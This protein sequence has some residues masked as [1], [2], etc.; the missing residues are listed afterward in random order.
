MR[1]GGPPATQIFAAPLSGPGVSRDGCPEPWVAA[2]LTQNVRPSPGESRSPPRA[3][4]A[5]VPE[6]DDSSS[7]SLASAFP[8]RPCLAL[9]PL[10][11]AVCQHL[12]GDFL[13]LPGE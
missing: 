7:S 9:L 3:P 12:A 5:L 2:Q 1:S 11:E 13:N 6:D 8:S 10:L 4:P